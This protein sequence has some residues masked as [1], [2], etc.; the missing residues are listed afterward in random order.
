MFEPVHGSA[1]DIAGRGWANPV[2]AV[3]SASMCLEHLGEA[4]AAAALERAAASVLPRLGAM[5]GPDMGM[6]TSEIGDAVA[7]AI[8]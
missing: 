8:G 1:P 2:A 3:V 4:E 5:G 6:S 7:A